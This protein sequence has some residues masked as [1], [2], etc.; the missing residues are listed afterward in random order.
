MQAFRVP[1]TA[2]AVVPHPPFLP[3][4][5]LTW[6]CAQNLVVMT[7]REARP[8]GVHVI[9]SQSVA[10]ALGPPPPRGSVRARLV[11]AGGVVLPSPTG[12]CDVM[13]MTQARGS[14][15]ALCPSLERTRASS[16]ADA[17]SSRALLHIRW[18]SGATCRRTWLRWWRAR[19]RWRWRLRRRSSA[20]TRCP[21]PSSPRSERC[22]TTHSHVCIRQRTASRVALQARKTQMREAQQAQAAKC[23]PAGGG[24]SSLSHSHRH[25]WPRWLPAQVQHGRVPGARYPADQAQGPPPRAFRQRRAAHASQPRALQ[26]SLPRHSPRLSARRRRRLDSAI[27]FHVTRAPTRC[28]FP[29]GLSLSL[30]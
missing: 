12:G 3:A 21:N 24:R 23:H 4:A 30:K 10:D 1:C 27:S 8:G 25:R 11:S 9:A 6:P 7:V 19:A 29:S 17:L 28:G 2:L 15:S 14:Q 26:A 20:A 16:C 22:H 18:T 5:W 13:F